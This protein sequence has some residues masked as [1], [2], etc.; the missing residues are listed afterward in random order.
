MEEMDALFQYWADPEH[1]II[2]AGQPEAII[3]WLSQQTPDTWHRVA[4]TWNYDYE[5][6]VLSWILRQENCDKGTAA[7][8]FDVEGGGHWLGDKKLE[9]N[10]DHLCSIVLNN[11]ARYRT[12]AFHHNPQYGEEIREQV[13]KYLDEGMYVGTPILEVVQYLGSRD[14]DSEFESEDGKIVV[15][16]DHWT[17][18]KGIQITE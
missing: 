10:P 4:M 14:A 3:D 17:R 16:F 8:V 13:K 7:R 6:K 18:V 15:A 11:W 1:I 9:K 5:D 2:Q 12:G